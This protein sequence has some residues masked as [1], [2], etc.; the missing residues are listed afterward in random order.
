MKSLLST[1]EAEHKKVKD[2]VTSLQS[3]L[4]K[5]K[6]AFEDLKKSTLKSTETIDQKTF[7]C[8]ELTQKCE[9][10]TKTVEDLKKQKKEIEEQ[11]QQVKILLEVFNNQS[12]EK[13]EV[14]EIRASE[15]RLQEEKAQLAQ[16]LVDLEQG[17]ETLIMQELSEKHK[18]EMETC[19]KEFQFKIEKL[20]KKAAELEKTAQEQQELANQYLK[21]IDSMTQVYEESQEQNSRILQQLHEKEQVVHNMMNEVWNFVII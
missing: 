8:K 15:R 1:K 16:K 17:K 4:S 9:T 6:T 7:E 12:K 18:Q 13:R 3:E 5:V 14:V 11:C 21:E 2:Q 19:T 20:E 10:L